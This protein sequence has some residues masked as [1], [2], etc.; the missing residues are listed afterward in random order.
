MPQWDSFGIDADITGIV[1]SKTVVSVT[2][3]IPGIDEVHTVWCM[4]ETECSITPHEQNP[5]VCNGSNPAQVA[6]KPVARSATDSTHRA[7]VQ[8]N[9]SKEK[10]RTRD[11]LQ[12]WKLFLQDVDPYGDCQFLSVAQ[13]LL[14]LD[15]ILKNDSTLISNSQR[16]D[17]AKQLRTDA[18]RCMG[19]NPA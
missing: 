5:S 3:K 19:E 18:V 1:R 10:K 15:R 9:Q 4:P 14:L 7:L 13:Q 8:A 16:T 12:E 6:N 11:F 2:L 17:L